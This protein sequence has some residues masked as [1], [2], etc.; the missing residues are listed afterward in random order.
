MMTGSNRP[1]LA[2]RIY[3][4]ILI[5]LIGT[6]SSSCSRLNPY[7]ELPSAPG[8]R[9]KVKVTKKLKNGSSE[10][11]DLRGSD[12]NIIYQDKVDSE[13]YNDSTISLS[14]G[15]VFADNV[16]AT[17]KEKISND[18]LLRNITGMALIPMAAAAMGLAVYG[19]NEET[20]LGLGLGSTAAFGSATFLQSPT[21]DRIYAAGI[22]A[23]QC[24]VIALQPLE[25]TDD[26]LKI[27][28]T[29]QTKLTEL[30]NKTA[31]F[32]GM[33]TPG[34]PYSA[35]FKAE[36]DELLKIAD[37][38]LQNAHENYLQ[39]SE[40]E[41]AVNKAGRELVSAVKKIDGQIVEAIVLSDKSLNSLL[42]IVSGLNQLSSNFSPTGN[43]LYVPPAT[44]NDKDKDKK[45]IQSRSFEF[46]PQKTPA[47]PDQTLKKKL[48]ELKGLINEVSNASLQ[49]AGLVNAIKLNRSQENLKSCGVDPKDF[50]QNITLSPTGP[51]VLTQGDSKP[52]MIKGGQH[53]W[54]VTVEKKMDLLIL[55]LN[56]FRLGAMLSPS[57]PAIKPRR[58]L[59]ACLFQTAAISSPS[60]K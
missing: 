12:G 54:K 53:P 48:K 38:T 1:T 36:A 22:K 59:T 50:I 40:L 11:Y 37:A 52:V 8:S 28:D 4:L 39:G 56:N 23:V 49:V 30:G 34:K 17:Y 47:D 42:T 9:D 31:L 13:A 14:D 5:F 60:S 45:N 7:V 10:E 35:D 18:A 58:A 25:V 3:S 2:L 55:K 27:I 29:L 21:R 16:A 44:D 26:E 51:F 41:R 46:N 57:R 20:V 32:K 33:L 15:I 24:S 43:P 6:I 19:G